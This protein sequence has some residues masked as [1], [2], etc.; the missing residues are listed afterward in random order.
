MKAFLEW[1][2]ANQINANGKYRGKRWGTISKREDGGLCMRLNV[3]YDEYLEPFLEN[4][5]PEFRELINTRADYDGCGRCMDGKCAFTGFDLVNPTEEQIEL[6][7]RMILFRV[8][9]IREGRIPRCSYVKL[10]RRG[11]EI[12]PCAVHKVCDPKCKAMK[13]Y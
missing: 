8:N 7:K 2:Q 10:S 4:E 3:Q 6:A 5:S 13:K 12:E 11:E 9:A 1:L